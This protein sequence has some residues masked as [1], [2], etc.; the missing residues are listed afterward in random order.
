M[1]VPEQT[2]AHHSPDYLR[3][4]ARSWGADIESVFGTCPVHDSLE[5]VRTRTKHGGKSRTE[6]E[7]MVK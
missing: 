5:C 2:Y 6:R 7:K 1:D 3:V 4:A